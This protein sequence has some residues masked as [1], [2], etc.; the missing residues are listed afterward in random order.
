VA[1][2]DVALST[3]SA[4]ASG[5]GEPSHVLRALGLDAAQARESVRFGL[6]RG[7]TAEEIEIVAG[8]VAEEVAALRQARR[9]GVA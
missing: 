4:C 1:L 3:G 7:T 5:R 8:R 2:R 6:G 9:A